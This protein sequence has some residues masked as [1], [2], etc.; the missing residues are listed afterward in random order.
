MNWPR[1]LSKSHLVAL[2]CTV[3]TVCGAPPARGAPA[4]STDATRPASRVV[5][6]FLLPFGSMIVPGVGQWANGAVGEGFAFLGVS[7]AALMFGAAM[8]AED[9][10]DEE[11]IPRSRD[12]QFEQLAFL[13][14]GDTGFLSAY[15]SFRRSLPKMKARGRYGFLPEATTLPKAFAAPFKFGFLRN[16]KTW[17]FL[18]IPAALVA[19]V[20]IDERD[21]DKLPFYWHDA[22]F[23]GG[24]SY[25]AGVS[26]EAVFRGYIFPWFNQMFGER[27]WLANA[28]Q[29]LLFG[30]AH[31]QTV[32]VPIVQTLSAFYWGWV[33]RS[34]D[35]SIEETIFQ[36]AW[37]DMIL[38]TGALLLDDGGDA[39]FSIELPTIHF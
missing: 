37:W 26:E 7:V 28:G 12:K 3:A 6:E 17:I 15:D 10:S 31:F 19:G 24:I 11:D 30:A 8:G 25:T 5:H 27:T 18:S 14:A 13:V 22:V 23:A 16:K 21:N 2:V 9:Q 29:A 32:D 39:R 1:I 4:D 34:S 20:A 36:H 35:W 33:V 38:F